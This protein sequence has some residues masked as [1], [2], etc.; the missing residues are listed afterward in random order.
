MT[1]DEIQHPDKG[2]QDKHLWRKRLP[3]GLGPERIAQLFGPDGGFQALLLGYHP[4]TVNMKPTK[5]N[6]Q[7]KKLMK[8]LLSTGPMWVLST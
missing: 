6:A 1:P 2:P 5:P 4:S 8:K 7:C 3:R